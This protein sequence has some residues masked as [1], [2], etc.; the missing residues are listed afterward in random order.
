MKNKDT[1]MRNILAFLLILDLFFVS[2]MLCNVFVMREVPLWFS[3]TFS[4]TLS[5]LAFIFY[6]ILTRGKK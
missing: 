1:I 5:V 2:G 6:W 4:I 3:V